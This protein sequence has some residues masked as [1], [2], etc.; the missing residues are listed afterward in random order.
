[1]GVPATETLAPPNPAIA[2]A[3]RQAQQPDQAPPTPNLPAGAMGGQTPQ[4]ALQAMPTPQ[5]PDVV[6][7]NTLFGKAAKMILGYAPTTYSIDPQTGKQVATQGAP[8]KPGQFFKNILAASVLGGAAAAGQNPEGGFWGGVGNGARAAQAN[9]KQKDLMRQQQAQKDFENKNAADKNARENSAAATQEKLA[10]AQIIASNAETLRSNVMTQGASW[11]QHQKEADRGV[12]H[13]QPYKDAGLQPVEQDVP[14]IEMM[15]TVHDRVVAG[16][17]ALDFEP[18]GVKAYNDPKTGQPGF[19]YTYTGYDPKGTVPISREVVAQWKK[20]G[21][22]KSDPLEFG[23]VSNLVDK[24][25]PV[26]ALQYNKLKEMDAKLYNDNYIREKNDL[27]SKEAD[28]RIKASKAEV[29]KDLA[30]KN[31]ANAETGAINETKNET[32][33]RGAALDELNKV[34]GDMS[35]LSPKSKIVLSESAKGQIASLDAE[36]KMLIDSGD[37]AGA[38]DRLSQADQWRSLAQQALT[39]TPKT[40]TYQGQTFANVPENQIDTFLK[41]HPGATEGSAAAAQPAPE[42]PI[43]ERTRQGNAARRSA[44]ATGAGVAGQVLKNALTSPGL[45][46]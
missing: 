10:Q 14:E 12:T 21:L 41:L 7:H 45:L 39:G 34:G 24:N 13:L 3:A 20:D 15:K 28:A 23:M 9:A 44:L 31:R 46:P 5:A 33:A 16:L 43:A 2:A 32:E 4:Q 40:F 29:A 26:E 8:Q 1:M 25:Q 6:D 19:Q 37:Q 22:D 30:E 38:K 35:K 18:T 36:A 17:P 27:T 11:D 42:I